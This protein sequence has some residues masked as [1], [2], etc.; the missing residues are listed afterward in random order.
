[1]TGKG[2]EVQPPQEGESDQSRPSTSR[3]PR[4]SFNPVRQ[5]HSDSRAGGEQPPLAPAPFRPRV[6]INRATGEI[7][8]A[9][10]SSSDVSGY[11]LSE[12]KP[13]RPHRRP[14][15]VVVH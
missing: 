12:P 15:D 7:T 8:V 11:E 3:G 5:T 9:G 1:M 10:A 2:K 13:K 4:Q 14:R 6:M